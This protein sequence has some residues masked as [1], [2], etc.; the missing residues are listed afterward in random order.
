MPVSSSVSQRTLPPTTGRFSSTSTLRP[1]SASRLATVHPHIP[2]P[3]TTASIVM[4]VTLSITY[5][6]LMPREVCSRTPHWRHFC[7]VAHKLFS[8]HVYEAHI[9]SFFAASVCDGEGFRVRVG[10]REWNCFFFFC[11]RHFHP[12]SSNYKA[13]AR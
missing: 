6:K 10:V 11:Q 13:F 3:A 1:A 8:A 5:Y 12:L 9:I 4:F 2:A 7:R